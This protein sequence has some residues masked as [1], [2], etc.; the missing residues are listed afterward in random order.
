MYVIAESR[1]DDESIKIFTERVRFDEEALQKERTLFA[2][3]K[4]ESAEKK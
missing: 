4:K 2:L 3:H 1:G